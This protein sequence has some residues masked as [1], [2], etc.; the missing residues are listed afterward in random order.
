MSRAVILRFCLAVSS[1]VRI[2]WRT[3]FIFSVGICSEHDLV[4]HLIPTQI[5]SWVGNSVDFPGFGL[6]LRPA[7]ERSSSIACSACA[8]CS[9]SWWARMMSSSQ[10]SALSFFSAV[11]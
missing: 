7:H 4:S 6:T 8:R 3:R 1:K 9:G 2:S 10:A 11:A 5:R